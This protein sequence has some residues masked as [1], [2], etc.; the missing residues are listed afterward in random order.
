MRLHY[1]VVENVPGYL[2]VSDPDT[3]RTK[4]EAEACARERA[5]RYRDDW[6]CKYQVLGNPSTGYSIRDWP[7]RDHDLGVVIEITACTE[8]ECA[9]DLAELEPD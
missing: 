8:G 4:R 3:C 2:P 9:E 7:Y 1:H 6:D 5:K